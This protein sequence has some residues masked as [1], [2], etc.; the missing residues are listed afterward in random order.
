MK[1][2]TLK[3]SYET[4]SMDVQLFEAEGVL[5]MSSGSATN[6]GYDELDYEYNFEWKK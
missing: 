4:P 5:C 6:E 3:P 2:K 1:H